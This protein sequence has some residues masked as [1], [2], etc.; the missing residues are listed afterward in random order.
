M[1]LFLGNLRVNGSVDK[2][3]ANHCNLTDLGQK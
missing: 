1:K 2:K 3:L